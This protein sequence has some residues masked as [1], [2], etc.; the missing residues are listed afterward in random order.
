MTEGSIQEE[1]ITTVYLYA[2]NIG[3]P[4]YKANANH[5]ETGNQHYH[6]NNGGL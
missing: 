6:N 5:H 4:Q 1:D 2:P 3:A